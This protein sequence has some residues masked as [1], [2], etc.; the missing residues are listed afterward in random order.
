[1]IVLGIDTSTP[2]TGV[3]LGSE[4][5][6]IGAA[7]LASH[8]RN[9][10]V[11]MPAVDQ[12][13]RWSSVGP[14]A[15]TGIAVGLGPGLFTGMRVGVA[16]AKTLAQALS[17]PIVGLASLDVLAFSVRH[18]RRLIC[19]TVDAKRGEIFYAFYRPVPGGVARQSGFEVGSPMRL[20]AELEASSEDILLV[21]NG[22][23]A[24]RRQLE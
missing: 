9:H 23:I 6:T 8:V 22:A 13:L 24:Y 11:V 20:T 3:A 21:G 4:Q 5:G 15:I 7:I 12:L 14:S 17:V 19:S 16:T 2:Q 1:M 10:E 18:A